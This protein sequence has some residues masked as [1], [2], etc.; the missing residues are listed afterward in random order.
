MKLWSPLKNLKADKSYDKMYDFFLHD[1]FA[2]ATKEGDRILKERPDHQKTMLLLGQIALMKKQRARARE[3]YN[4][5]LEGSSG[6]SDARLGRG[7]ASFG[8][9]EYEA[10]LDDYLTL[11]E[12]S[13]KNFPYMQKLGAVYAALGLDHVALKYFK[14]AVDFAPANME[15]QFALTKHLLRLKHYKDA[16]TQI[17]IA[18]DYYYQNKASLSP[19]VFEQI[20]MLEEQIGRNLHRKK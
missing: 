17:K 6:S 11:Y 9:K 13:R 18:K 3:W 8:K 1:N 7:D 12:T 10:A 19:Q 16:D 5:T 2:A 14:K 15:A 20:K 4:K